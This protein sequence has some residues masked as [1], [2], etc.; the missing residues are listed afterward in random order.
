MQKND[1][2]F[3][4]DVIIR[5]LEVG[6]NRVLMIDCIRRTMPQSGTTSKPQKSRSS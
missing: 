3:K 5:V 4:D 1:L 2:Y 6:E